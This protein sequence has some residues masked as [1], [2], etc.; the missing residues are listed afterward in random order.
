[1][2]NGP[3]TRTTAPLLPA[4]GVNPPVKTTLNVKMGIVALS[5]IAAYLHGRAKS[6]VGLAIWG[7]VAAL[8]ALAAVLFGVMIS[9][10]PS[11]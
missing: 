1:M 9:E 5:G 4:A 8:A 2:A 11:S 10:A 3:E 7:A 6:K